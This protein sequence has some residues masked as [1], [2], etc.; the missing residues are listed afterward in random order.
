MAPIKDHIFVGVK[1]RDC[2]AGYNVNLCKKVDQRLICPLCSRLIRNPV[3]TF[4]GVLACASCYQHAKRDGRC[5][6]DGE[7][8]DCDEIFVDKARN[9]EIMILDC[10]CTH[11]E[12]GCTWMGKLK[13]LEEHEESCAFR[14]RACR[15]CHEEMTNSTY[16]TNHLN[17]CQTWLTNKT[18]L[19]QECS[20]N[21]NSIEDLKSHL[22][23]EVFSHAILH[24][25]AMEEFQNNFRSQ[26]Q[27]WNDKYTSMENC[28]EDLK[29]Q[30]QLLVTYTTDLQ[31]KYGIKTNM[32]ENRIKQLESERSN[33]TAIS[34]EQCGFSPTIKHLSDTVKSVQTNISDLNLRQQL[35]QN[36]AQYGKMLWK[37]DNLT[38]R[39]QKAQNGSVTALHSAPV[40]TNRFGYK[41]CGR[42]YLN[43]DGIGKTTHASM[44]I[45]LMKGD[46]DEILA[47]PFKGEIKFRLLNQKKIDDDV[48]ESFQSDHSSVS[49][50]QPKNETNVASGCPLFV[51]QHKLWNGGFVKNDTIFIEISVL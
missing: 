25:S 21:P 2:S 35:F 46:Y 44:F 6:I 4:R 36:S 48:V 45:V 34:E 18:C 29:R 10:Y 22:Q 50:A 20:Y 37:I 12:E 7:V 5:P 23:N 19:Y 32:L 43:G 47:W 24:T 49:F 41:F 16:T 17:H 1:R 14:P 40:Y 3:Q 33:P 27:Y 15:F 51:K 39:L 26:K 31:N 8:I 38:E 28:V 30:I 9:N 42:L 11:Q 13:M